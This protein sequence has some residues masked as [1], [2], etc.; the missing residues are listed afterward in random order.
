M[1]HRWTS[2]GKN[3]A[4]LDNT[5]SGAK[6]R[7]ALEQIKDTL[8]AGGRALDLKIID[9]KDHLTVEDMLDYAINLVS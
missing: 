4:I 2:Q 1:Y 8:I 9:S 5:P 3:R 6:I 7:K